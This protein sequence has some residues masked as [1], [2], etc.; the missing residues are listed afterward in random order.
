MHTNCIPGRVIVIKKGSINILSVSARPAYY[1]EGRRV[2]LAS[3]VFQVN[4]HYEIRN[5]LDY[6]TD[7]KYNLNGLDGWI[8]KLKRNAKNLDFSRKL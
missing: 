1:F 2:A 4:L 7:I 3:D 5:V 8:R 6:C